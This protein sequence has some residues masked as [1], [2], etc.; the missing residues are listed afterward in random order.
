MPRNT[1]AG[2]GTFVLSGRFLRLDGYNDVE[3][4]VEGGSMLLLLRLAGVLS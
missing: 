3:G 2:A 4:S 1:H